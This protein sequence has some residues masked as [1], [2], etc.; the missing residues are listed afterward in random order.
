MSLFEKQKE[1]LLAR[2]DA[3]LKEAYALPKSSESW[4]RRLYID[5]ELFLL[6]RR[7]AQLFDAR[8]LTSTEPSISQ[9]IQDREKILRDRPP[10]LSFRHLS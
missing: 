10:R 3:L 4:E 9:G 8:R 2:I 7:L 6:F 1:E 5:W